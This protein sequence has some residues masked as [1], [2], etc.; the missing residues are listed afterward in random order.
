MASIQRI[1]FRLSLT[2]QEF[3]H[4]YQGHAQAVIVRAEDGR[5]IQIPAHILRKFVTPSGISGRF[6]MRLDSTNKMLS[7]EQIKG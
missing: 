6:E 3:L 7:I 4:Y 5:R 1:R 2:S